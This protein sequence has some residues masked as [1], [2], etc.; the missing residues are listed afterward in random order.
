MNTNITNINV[1]QSRLENPIEDYYCNIVPNLN[2]KLNVRRLRHVLTSVLSWN[3]M[4]FA[5]SFLP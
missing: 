2:F 3:V 4:T 5:I 1:I